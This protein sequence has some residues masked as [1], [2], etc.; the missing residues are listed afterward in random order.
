MA[1]FVET[2]QWH[3]CVM[4][5]FKMLCLFPSCRVKW[6]PI[7]TS[8][9]R[10]IAS[11]QYGGGRCLVAD[12]GDE[13]LLLALE[14]LVGSVVAWRFLYLLRSKLISGNCFP[15]F[16]SWMSVQCSVQDVAFKTPARPILRREHILRETDPVATGNTTARNIY[17]PIVRFLTPS[18]ESKY[19][20]NNI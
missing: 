2:D 5:H 12:N 14:K 1:S 8:L 7:M 17:S 16:T 13:L 10:I 4:S 18:K 15:P 11:L 20:N 6:P 19:G 3:V 9:M